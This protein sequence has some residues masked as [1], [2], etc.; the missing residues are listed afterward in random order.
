MGRTQK[1][2]T[3]GLWAIVVIGMLAS[4]RRDA[5]QSRE[6]ATPGKFAPLYDAPAFALVNQ[7]GQPFGKSD[8]AGNVWIADFIFI[9]CGGPCPIMTAKLAD[10]QKQV[11][12]P[13]VKLVSFSVDPARHAQRAE[14]IR[15]AF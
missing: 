6:P 14:G 8:L 10:I 15:K 3:T 11:G 5:V 2:V 13:D 4:S 7:D 1:I 12:R 9:N